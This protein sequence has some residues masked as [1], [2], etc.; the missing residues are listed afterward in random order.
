[1]SPSREQ[2]SA[3]RKDGRRCEAAALPGDVHCFAHSER[4]KQ[5]RDQA[6]RNGGKSRMKAA[7]VLPTAPDVVITDIASVTRFLTE[8]AS[9]AR[10][11]DI[12]V[13]LANCLGY[14]AGQMLK[15]LQQGEIEMRLQTLEEEAARRKE[16]RGY[17]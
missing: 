16:R 8:T 12:D 7:A 5:A 11:G 15:S 6:R 9:Q 2:C 3:T 13:K 14:L 4:T 1:M 10:R 17:A